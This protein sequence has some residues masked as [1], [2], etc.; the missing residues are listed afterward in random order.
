MQEDRLMWA[1][2]EDIDE[3][4]VT[5]FDTCLQSSMTIL[6]SAMAALGR[7]SAASEGAHATTTASPTSP[8]TRS[9]A[10][11]PGWAEDADAYRA[12]SGRSSS[13]VAT[14]G[15]QISASAAQQLAASKQWTYV[16]LDRMP[17]RSTTRGLVAQTGAT[18][19]RDTALLSTRNIGVAFA[20]TSGSH[21][22]FFAADTAEEAAAWV[23]MI[24][25]AWFHCAMNSVR[26]T[27]GARHLLSHGSVRTADTSERSEV[28]ALRIEIEQLRARLQEFGNSHG[29]T[30]DL[31]HPGDA[32]SQ[33]VPQQVLRNLGCKKASWVTCLAFTS[34]A[35][36]C[37][38]MAI[39]DLH[40][41][42]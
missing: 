42:P 15:Q 19:L 18:L 38:T 30:T 16:T 23:A 22:L 41:S 39:P 26:S 35:I 11:T 10:A 12:T 8:G 34:A 33:Q 7:G 29:H 13:P 27:R 21:T 28:T 1:K 6:P 36:S 32:D 14:T 9:Q 20:V 17:V 40:S 5:A 37:S 24:K 25:Q 2:R 3:S 4:A 31:V